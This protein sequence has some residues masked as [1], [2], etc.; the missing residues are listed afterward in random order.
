MIA[1]AG[2]KAVTYHF[3]RLIPV[4]TRL[5]Q[6]VEASYE[7]LNSFVLLMDAAIE[8]GPFENHV[9]TYLKE[10]IK[11][12]Q[13]RLVALP[14]VGRDPR[15]SQRVLRILAHT[16]EE[17]AHLSSS[18]S[19][20]SP[21]AIRNCSNLRFQRGHSSGARKS[22]VEGGCKCRFAISSHF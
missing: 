1:N 14:L 22:N 7:L 10:A 15:G 3:L 13:Y 4:I 21:E 19:A 17:R 8:L 18:S 6:V 5:S 2:D 12:V 16:V 11:L 20:D 9:A